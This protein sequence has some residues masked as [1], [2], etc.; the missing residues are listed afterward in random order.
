MK[1][2]VNGIAHPIQPATL[3]REDPRLLT[4]RGQYVSDVRL[5]GMLEAAVLRSPHAHARILRVDL[6]KVRTAPGVV[7]ALAHDDVAAWARPIPQLVPYPGLRSQ[8]SPIL[9]QGVVRYVGE[10]VAVVVAENRY[11]AED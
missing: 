8:T 3:R 10:P 6:E 7:A 4:G 9:A 11:Q 5:P 2:S 1:S